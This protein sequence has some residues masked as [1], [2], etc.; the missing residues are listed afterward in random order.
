MKLYYPRND[1]LNTEI[2]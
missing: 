1:L 2:C